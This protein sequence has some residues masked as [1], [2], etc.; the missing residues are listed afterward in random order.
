MKTTSDGVTVE[1]AAG[2]Q[3]YKAILLY[4]GPRQINAILPSAVPAGAATVTVVN[5]TRSN[6]QSITVVKSSFGIFARNQGGS[7][8]GI[9]QNFVSELDRPFNTITAVAHPN[10]V[11]TIWGTGLGPV[12]FDETKP[13]VQGPLDVTVEV[14]VGSKRAAV[15]YRG[16]SSYAGLDQINIQLPPDVPLGCYVPLTVRIGSGAAAV[17]SNAITIAVA[18]GTA[19]ACSDALSFGGQSADV[20]ARGGKFGSVQLGRVSMKMEGFDFT[21]DV[22]SATFV[23]WTPEALAASHG[24]YGVSSFDSCVTYTYRGEDA[25]FADPILPAGLDAGNPLVLTIPG[26]GTKNLV[27]QANSKGY[28]S[29]PSTIDPTNP[30]LPQPWLTAGN[31]TIDVPGGVDVAKFTRLLTVPTP[32]VWTNMD[33][34]TDITR[35]SG[36]QVQWSGGDTTDIVLISGASTANGVGGGFYCITQNNKTSFTVPADVLSVLPV[37]GAAQQDGGL[38]MVGSTASATKA[39]MN[40]KP[41]DLDVATFTYSFT[42]MKLVNYK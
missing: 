18:G 38:L 11:L 28:Y 30:Q 35:S 25:E 19:S 2:G 10:Q 26:G 3:T 37:T 16:R 12:T 42:S 22:A 15:Q 27:A 24:S 29:T 40:P 13:P 7:G 14:T 6:A 17:V 23:R 20:A 4:I 31:Y 9:V 33:A 5:G 8:P 21:T 32:L 41:A 34:L 36:V 39:A 1:I